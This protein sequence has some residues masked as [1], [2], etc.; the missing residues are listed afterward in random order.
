MLLPHPYAFTVLAASLLAFWA[1]SPSAAAVT[2]PSVAHQAKPSELISGNDVESIAALLRE[3]GYKAQVKAND[4]GVRYIDSAANGMYFTL[5]FTDCDI[6]SGCA[7]LRFLAWWE[8]PV[9]FSLKSANEWN[10]SY[11][12][13][14]AAI[15]PEGDLVLDYYLSLKGG[16]RRENFLD[17][18][19]WW[20]LL[21]VDFRQ[22]MDKQADAAARS[23]AETGD[24]G[25]RNEIG[26]D[27]SDEDRAG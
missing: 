20:A 2:K 14:R 1:T 9:G 11:K 7:S 25:S 21:L 6:N 19:D 24:S 23:K 8:R 18:F 22:F 27:A 12:L 10:N 3:A 15:D 13:A 17:I 26:P 5:S 16:V 4:D